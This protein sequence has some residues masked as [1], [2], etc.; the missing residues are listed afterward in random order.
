MRIARE[1]TTCMWGSDDDAC[2]EADDATFYILNFIRCCSW[3]SVIPI[4]FLNLISSR[5]WRTSSQQEH[6]SS[7]FTASLV[8]YVLAFLHLLFFSF[9]LFIEYRPTSFKERL[10]NENREEN[11]PVDHF[12]DEHRSRPSS[13][14]PASRERSVSPPREQLPATSSTT[15]PVLP[16]CRLTLPGHRSAAWWRHCMLIS[17]CQ[18]RLVCA[19]FV[20]PQS[21]HCTTPVTRLYRCEAAIIGKPKPG[22]PGT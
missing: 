17:A 14:S 18:T 2:D 20:L 19:F 1:W 15:H 12:L 21:E 5:W 9:L 22:A 11:N 6:E 7:V 4:F 10:L 3:F 13:P 16:T 8:H